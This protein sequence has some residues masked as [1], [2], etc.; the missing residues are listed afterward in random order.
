MGEGDYNNL[1]E[2]DMSFEDD[3]FILK[4]AQPVCPKCLKPYNPQMYYCPYCDT[5]D[6][7]NPLSTYMPYIRI[8]FSYGFFGRMWN[9]VWKGKD[10]LLILRILCFFMMLF[11]APMILVAGIPFVLIEKFAPV[12]R[13]DSLNR[14]FTFLVILFLI[15]IC[16]F[17]LFIL[18]L[19]SRPA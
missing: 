12:S 9:I 7:I 8:R 3:E 4:D 16:F 2:Q 17:W 14:I 15:F 11:F 5:N 1:A 6:T 13:R 10:R 19:L 18:P